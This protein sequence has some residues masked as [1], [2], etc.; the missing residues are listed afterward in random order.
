M[1]LLTNFLIG[2]HRCEQ[3][4]GQAVE[5][6]CAFAGKE[7]EGCPGALVERYMGLFQQVHHLHNMNPFVCTIPALPYW[8]QGTSPA[9]PS[10]GRIHFASQLRLPGSLQLLTCKGIIVGLTHHC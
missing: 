10:L 8:R 2:L 1:D 4:P 3:L 5:A 6:D 7:E 9:W